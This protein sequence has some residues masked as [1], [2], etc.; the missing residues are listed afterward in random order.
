MRAAD[1]LEH[2]H[3]AVLA[4]VKVARGEAEATKEADQVNAQRIGEFADFFRNFV[5]RCHHGK[6]EKHL[7][8][9]LEERGVPREGGPIG[10]MLQEHELGRAEVRAIAEA[11]TLLEQGDG[12]AAEAIKQ[13]LLAYADLLEAHI[14]KE[15][16]ILFPMGDR[17]LTPDDQQSLVDAF[18]AVEREEMGEGTHERYHQ[19]IHELVQE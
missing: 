17:V 19:W 14:Q 16:G 13:H 15:N 3:E 9:K 11:L 12:G 10:V 1:I 2:E 8:L 6:E 7:F 18:D 5:D 4:V